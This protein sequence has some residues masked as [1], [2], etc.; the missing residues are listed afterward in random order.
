MTKAAQQ[1][2][3]VLEDVVRAGKRARRRGKPG[4]WHRLRTSSR[5]LRGALIAH[6][7][8]FDPADEKKIEKR[9]RQVTKLPADV[10]ELDVALTNLAVLRAQ[11]ES[12]AER[13]AARKL[14]R[15]LRRERERLDRRARRR[16]E[17]DRPVRRLARPLQKALRRAAREGRPDAPSSDAVATCARELLARREAIGDWDDDQS[18]HAL[19]VAGKRLRG[20][21]AAR[22]EAGA[23]RLPVAVAQSLEQ[24]HTLLGEHHD[25]S[26]LGDRLDLERCKLLAEGARHRGL[27]GYELLLSRARDQQ[28]ARY[29]RYRA[30]L[31]DRVPAL[32]EAALGKPASNDNP[33]PVQA[34]PA[35]SA[36]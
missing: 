21:F 22:A 4:D 16:L 28:K 2:E 27:I 34:L 33:V 12:R 3:A 20:A 36:H 17:R 11:A 25:W 6:A 5:K 13:Q 24:M 10:R 7:E 18:L 29:D 1:L 8:L 32:V 19:R 35:A 9:A 31:H 14:R 23:G 26:E 15:R 30:E